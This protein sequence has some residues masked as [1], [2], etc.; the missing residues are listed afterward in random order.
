MA[1]T[2]RLL[3]LCLAIPCVALPSALL[4]QSSDCTGKAA[5]AQLSS[6]DPVYVDATNLAR[7]LIDHGFIVKCVQASKWGN[8]F[9]GQEGAALYRTEQGDFD[10]L[11]LP[12]AETFDAVQVVEQ[13]QGNLYVYSFRGTPN[14]AGRLE[15]QKIHFVRSA[16]LLFLVWS[17]ADLT[18]SIQA[19]VAVSDRSFSR[20]ILVWYGETLDRTTDGWNMEWLAALVRRGASGKRR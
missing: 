11:F 6:I 13:M 2:H 18:A 9:A 15:G 7:N 4:A 20:C 10:V 14:S 17:D 19:T 8:L 1:R 3:A 16:N 12:K 5:Q